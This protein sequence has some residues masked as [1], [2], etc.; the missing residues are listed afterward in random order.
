MNEIDRP[1]FDNVLKDLKVKKL[2]S[3]KNKITK[4]GIRKLEKTNG[5]FCNA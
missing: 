2:I 3:H 5:S 4:K 1:N